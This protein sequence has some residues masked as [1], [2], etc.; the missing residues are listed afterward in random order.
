MYQNKVTIEEAQVNLKNIVKDVEK[1]NVY[2]IT[3]DDKPMAVLSSAEKTKNI[4]KYG[5]AKGKLIIKPDFD[6]PIDEFN[7]Y[8]R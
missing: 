1:G 2:I 7:E 8:M 6:A 5:S 4:P 3:I